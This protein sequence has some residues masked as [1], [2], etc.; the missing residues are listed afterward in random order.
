MNGVI[1]IC[2]Y[3]GYSLTHPLSLLI[4][5]KLMLVF[6]HEKVVVEGSIVHVDCGVDGMKANID[7]F[8]SSST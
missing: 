3:N 8:S 4:A 2:N 1:I 6:T 7:G 5:L